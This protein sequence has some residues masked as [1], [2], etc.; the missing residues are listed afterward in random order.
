[1]FTLNKFGNW[2]NGLERIGT[3]Q[4]GDTFNQIADETQHLSNDIEHRP[5]LSYSYQLRCLLEELHIC[6]LD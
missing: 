5:C 2:V 3:N 6:R 1:M 4:H